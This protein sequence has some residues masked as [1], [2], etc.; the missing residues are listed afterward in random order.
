MVIIDAR[1]DPGIGRVFAIAARETTIEQ[2]LRFDP[3]HRYD[4]KYAEGPT[5]A[6]GVVTWPRAI[7]YCE[8]L[9]RRAGLAASG[10]C[11]AR[12][13]GRPDY[14]K[15]LPDLTRSGYR[16]PTRAEWEFA[17]RAGTVTR[18]YYGN[19]GDDELLH[20]YMRLTP[21]GEEPR[22][23]PVGR[24]MPNDFGLFDM[25]GNACEWNADAPNQFGRVL[26]SGGGYKVLPQEV[27]SRNWGL[28]LPDVRYNQNGFRIA[29]TIVLDEEGV[30]R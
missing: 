3:A 22:M 30:P 10:S 26:I 21:R 1:H 2:M 6:I 12:G 11:Y 28:S 14:S 20:H 15:I 9:N 5:C 24:L 16:L 19:D 17:C 18:R 7:D 29:R 25:Y 13:D 23:G 4:K 8:W 27:S